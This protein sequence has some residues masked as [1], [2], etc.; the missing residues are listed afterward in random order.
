MN[1]LRFHPQ[2]RGRMPGASSG[3]TLVEFAFML[4]VLA[5][6]LF[7]VFEV[8]RMMQ[9]WVTIQHAVDEAARFAAPGALYAAGAGV[10]E[11]AIIQVAR[12]ACA[13]LDIRPSAGSDGPGHFRVDLRSSRSIPGSVQNNAGGP[14]DFLRVEIYY[15]HSILAWPFNLRR[16]VTLHAEAL[17]INERF[18]RP[19]GE[20]GALPPTPPPAVTETA[21]PAPPT[22]SPTPGH[23]P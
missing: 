11:T 22:P 19:T 14:N 10:R 4:P 12:D 1:R 7:G 20:I 13:G 18:A 17:V 23:Y 21:T 15:N 6:L 3:Q 9:S 5:A 16:Y 8:G 2:K